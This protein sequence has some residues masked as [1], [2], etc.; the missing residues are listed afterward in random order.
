MPV[1]SAAG[2]NSSAF[3]KW[4]MEERTSNG[5]LGD[6]QDGYYTDRDECYR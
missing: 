2:E 6:L 1:L 3:H 5:C 4:K